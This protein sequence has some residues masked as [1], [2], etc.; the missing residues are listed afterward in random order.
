AITNTAVFASTLRYDELLSRAVPLPRIGAGALGLSTVDALL[1]ACIHRV[2]HHHDSDR[3]IWLCDVHL[4]RRSLTSDELRT[5]WELAADRRVVA[6]CRRAFE[7]ESSW[8]GSAAG[9]AERWLS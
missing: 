7:L 5:F 8:F 1:H 9:D 6:V 2:A 4:L 3:L